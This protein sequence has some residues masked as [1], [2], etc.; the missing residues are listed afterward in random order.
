[1]NVYSQAI[2]TEWPN[3]LGCTKTL[4]LNLLI[5]VR[6]QVPQLVSP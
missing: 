5:L 3:G 2:L 1:M 6:V 4:I